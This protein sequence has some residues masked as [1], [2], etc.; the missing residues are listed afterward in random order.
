MPHA[1]GAQ[2]VEAPAAQEPAPSQLLAAVAAPSVHVA[3][4]HVVLASA[5]AHS[6]VV[7][8]SHA[9]PHALPSVAQAARPP[10]GAPVT[11]TQVP[12]LPATSHASHC[13]PH[14]V[15]QQTPSAQKP[16]V[17]SASPPH[18]SP[19]ASR[20]VHTPAEQN[21]VALQ[22]PSTVQSPAQSTGPHE[23]GAQSCVRSAGQ[24]PVPT[25]V[26]S[27]TAT[28]PVHDPVRQTVSAPG[29]VHPAVVVPSHVPSQPVP[30]PAH[31]ARPP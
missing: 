29:N 17:H 8:P 14:A 26:S 5:Y 2:L 13:S 12:S 23:N 16:E 1:Y 9:P 28:P 15:A 24:L 31:A 22:S 7:V 10:C 25:Q 21:A 6:V 20:G 4:A 18:V 19:S 3:S 27:R 11:A 30:S